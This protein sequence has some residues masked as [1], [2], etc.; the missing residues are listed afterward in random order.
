MR[1]DQARKAYDDAYSQLT[2]GAGNLVGQTDKLS[3]LGARHAK[4]LEAGMLEKA[5]GDS[6]EDEGHLRLIKKDGEEQT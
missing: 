1:L 4:Q 6:I 2:T 5:V 3:K